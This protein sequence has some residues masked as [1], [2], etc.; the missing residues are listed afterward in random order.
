M[1][2]VSVRGLVRTEQ[3]KRGPHGE[4]EEEDPLAARVP[5]PPE[6]LWMR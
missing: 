2:E 6:R 1:K 3:V 5:G 4:I